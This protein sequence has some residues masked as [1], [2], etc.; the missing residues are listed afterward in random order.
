MPASITTIEIIDY[1]P[2]SFAAVLVALSNQEV[3]IY[4]EKFL[5]DIIK[6]D[7]VVTGLQ[8]ERFGREDGTLVMTTKRK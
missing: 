8:F 4:K 7:D 3:H 5:V 2:R 1:R 6:M